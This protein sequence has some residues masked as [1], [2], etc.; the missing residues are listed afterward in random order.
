M[1]KIILLT[2]MGLC[3]NSYSQEKTE[4]Q[5]YYKVTK[6][7]LDGQ[8]VSYEAS[9]KDQVLYFYEC[10][11]GFCFENLCRNTHSFSRGEAADIKSSEFEGTNEYYP[12][13]NFDFLWKFYNSYDDVIGNAKVNFTLIYIEDVIKFSCK[14]VVLET[15]SIL[16]LEGYME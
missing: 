16:E 13:T 6:F 12:H 8:D 7:I 4:K 5:A 15:N 3:I 2:L 11:A 10:N 9:Q 14:I 1:K